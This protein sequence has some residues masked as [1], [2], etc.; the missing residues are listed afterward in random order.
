MHFF[1]KI[2]PYVSQCGKILW[3]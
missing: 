1:K 3:R 2:L